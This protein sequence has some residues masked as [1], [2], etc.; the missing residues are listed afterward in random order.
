MCGASLVPLSCRV[1]EAWG[2]CDS[3]VF[4]YACIYTTH[5]FLKSLAS[6]DRAVG[7]AAL[8]LYI[9]VAISICVPFKGSLCK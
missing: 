4:V 1:A 6:V 8:P 5:P 9:G 2:A 7:H 3:H